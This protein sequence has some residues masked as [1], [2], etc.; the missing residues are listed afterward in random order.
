MRK[1]KK[2]LS[3]LVAAMLAAGCVGGCGWSSG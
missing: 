1:S 2:I 3:V